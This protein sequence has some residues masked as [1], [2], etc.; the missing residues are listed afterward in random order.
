MLTING[1][2]RFD[3]GRKMIRCEW[4]AEKLEAYTTHFGIAKSRQLGR[5][6]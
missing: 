1:C 5:V 3:R 6:N 4:F 2:V